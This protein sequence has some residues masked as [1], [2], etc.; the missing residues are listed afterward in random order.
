MGRKACIGITGRPAL[1]YLNL[2]WGRGCHFYQAAVLETW[3]VLDF[4]AF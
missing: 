1:V 3:T 4:I 2:T